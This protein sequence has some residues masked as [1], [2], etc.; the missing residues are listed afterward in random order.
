MSDTESEK[1]RR[2][3]PWRAII[4]VAAIVAA[5]GAAIALT[6]NGGETSPYDTAAIDQGGIVRAVSATGGLQPLVTVDVGSTVSGPMKSVEVDF[7]TAVKRG[8]VLARIDPQTFQARVAQAEADLAVQQASLA[9]AE[10]DAVTAQRDWER[11]QKLGETG[12]ASGQLVDQRRGVFERTAAAVKL[13]EARV[14]QAQ[15]G[16]ANARV[17]LERSIIRAPVDGVVVD[18]RV[19]PGQSVAAS[20]Q[21]PTLFRIAQDLTRLQANISVDEADIGDVREGMAVRFTVDA[22]PGEDFT[23]RVAQVR[24]QGQQTQGVVSYV[25]VVQAENPSGRLLPGMTANA[26]IILEEKPNVSRIPNAALR[27]RPAD[28]EIAAKARAL[29]TAERPA[30]GA[31]QAAPQSS[32]ESGG[33]G[34]RM[35]EELAER[36]KL[37]EAQKALARD[38]FQ[39]ARQS[40]GAVPGPDAAP[41]ERRAFMRKVRETAMRQ[42]ETTL[43]PEQK[44]LLTDL[45]AASRGGGQRATPAVV[46]VLRESEPEPV[47]IRIGIADSGFTELVEGLAPG[48]E[49]IIGGGPKPRSGQQGPQGGG[50]PGIRIRGA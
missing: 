17:D 35:V 8:Q 48:D 11:Y 24:K 13:A 1:P 43:T 28:P 3:M 27:F 40:A 14:R 26:E 47:R 2:R 45:R 44:T 29:A 15:A 42:I 50:P 12:I 18:R 30:D 6:R 46:W 39:N 10:A 37:T 19:D 20:F 5:L 49:V 16:L 7:N 38:A 22:F 33:R 9:S 25:V 21:A 41:E 32:G 34:G 4:V 36:L 31:A 23:G